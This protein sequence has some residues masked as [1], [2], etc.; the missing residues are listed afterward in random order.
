MPKASFWRHPAT[1]VAAGVV[2]LAVVGP[3]IS[4]ALGARKRK[5]KRKARRGVSIFGAT[6]CPACMKLKEDFEAIGLAH[7]FRDIDTDKAANEFVMR[8][9][10]GGAIPVVTINGQT[11]IGYNRAAIEEALDVELPAAPPPIEK[12]TEP[13]LMPEGYVY[14]SSAYQLPVY[15]N[16][17]MGGRPFIVYINFTEASIF[18]DTF[19]LFL[20]L[21]KDNPDVAFVHV[22]RAAESAAKGEPFKSNVVKLLGGYAGDPPGSWRCLQIADGP[23]ATQQLGEESPPKAKLACSDL[24]MNEPEAVADALMALA[25]YA[26][27]QAAGVQQASTT[28]NLG[29]AI[30]QE[31]GM[32]STDVN[33]QGKSP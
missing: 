5:P 30:A 6:W 31:A 22:D 26:Q 12:P 24:D 10:E 29:A 3:R 27:D 13:T 17:I 16:A 15:A 33:A 9:S 1:I 20:Q 19:P 8:T 7:T 2:G 14:M 11:I 28:T 18:D 4:K 23:N 25:Q 21:V 32:S